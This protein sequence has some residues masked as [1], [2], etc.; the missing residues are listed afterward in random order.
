MT[1]RLQVNHSVECGKGFE[2]DLEI[3]LVGAH[4]G[5]WLVLDGGKMPAGL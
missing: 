4:I 1:R 2:A 3:R 5:G